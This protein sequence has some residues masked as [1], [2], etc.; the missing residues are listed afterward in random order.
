M[1][2]GEEVSEIIQTMWVGKFLSD[3]ELLCLN[4]FVKNGHEIHLY[5]YDEI[6]NVPEGVVVKDGE[7]ILSSEHIFQYA[8]HKSYSAFSNYFRY[9]LLYDKGGYWVDTD[10]V[11]LKKFDFDSLYVFC[12]EEVLPLNAGNTHVGSCIIKAPK[13]N[14]I[15]KEASDI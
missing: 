12:S 14:I 2:K 6:S 4:S 11:C 13:D 10:V 9:K 8:D 15:V 7:E 3:M 5:A 1:G